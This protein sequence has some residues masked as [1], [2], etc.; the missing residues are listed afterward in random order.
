M[1]KRDDDERRKELAEFLRNRRARVRPDPEGRPTRRR[2]PG[3]R[4]EEV[5]EI[6]GTSVSW[7]TWL[8]QAR[9]IRPS[10]EL[11][12]RLS[13]ALKLEPFETNHLFNL[14]GKSPPDF[15]EDN[16][17]DV[18]EALRHLVTNVIRVPAF[19]MSERTD[20]LVWNRQFKDQI[21]NLDEVPPDRR[22]LLDMTFLLNKAF[23]DT[24][25]WK[26]TARRIVA[27]FRWS[28]GKQLG[29]PWVKELVNRVCRESAEFAQLWRLHDIQERKRSR[30]LEVEDNRSYVRSIYI[31]AEAENLRLVILAPVKAPGRRK[32]R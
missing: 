31:P 2:T 25:Q 14:A 22:T 16:S 13:Q 23:H 4:R 11:L 3:L 26:E 21:F 24:P 27:E 12:V 7:Y 20:F 19:V 29:S 6:S 15:L 9:D 30:V 1:A 10:T 8:E 5:A 18:P 28:V 32:A 17:D